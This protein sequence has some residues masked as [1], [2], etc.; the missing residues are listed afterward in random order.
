MIFLEIIAI[1]FIIFII[2]PQNSVSMLRK[3]GVLVGK[4]RK[5][6]NQLKSYSKDFN[7]TN[8]DNEVAGNKNSGVNV[9]NG[10]ADHSTTV[11]KMVLLDVIEASYSINM[12]KN[13][14][15]FLFDNNPDIVSKTITILKKDPLFS[16]E[17]RDSFSNWNVEKLVRNPNSEYFNK[18]FDPNR[19][20]EV[21]GAIF[22]IPKE[23]FEKHYKNLADF[24]GIDNL[25]MKTIFSK[26][27]SSFFGEFKNLRKKYI[28]K[29]YPPQGF[30]SPSY[31]CNLDCSYCFSKDLLQK[32]NN[33]MTV[34]QFTLYLK[35]LKADYNIKEIGFFGGEPTYFK[36]LNEFIDVVE[37]EKLFCNIAS[38]GIV[39]NQIWEKIVSRG[40]LAMITFHIED[41]DFYT[42]DTHLPNIISNIKSANQ[43]KKQITFRYNI[44]DSERTDWSFL[45]K[46]IDLVSQFRFSFAIPFPSGNGEN[47]YVSLDELNKF[48]KTIVSMIDHIDFYSRNRPYEIVLAK[49]IP[50]CVFSEKEYLRILE[51]VRYKNVCEIDK[52]NNTNNL[53]I[54]PDGSYQSCVGLNKDKYIFNDFLG[55]ESLPSSYHMNI[56]RVINKPM[57]DDCKKC[58]LFNIGVCQGAC[59]A[60][61]Q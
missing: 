57:M 19:V 54:N 3:A 53:I 23:S 13:I 35:K 18:V 30:V 8:L 28:A 7:I 55:Q 21:S 9:N 15:P 14:I 12:T 16:F 11:T 6:I 46:Y 32:F 25:N 42:N 43:F 20:A 22:S 58:Y 34:E 37:N 4:L 59:Y 10:K 41:N 52:N 50:L 60:Y 5:V 31:R 48:G 24:N 17:K 56:D 33:D 29:C 44:V 61:T 36:K 26:D 47:E 40:S 27:K 1:L 39:E 38:N 2:N 51:K 45:N 49:P